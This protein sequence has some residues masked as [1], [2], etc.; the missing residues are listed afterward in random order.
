VY[1]YRT[2]LVEPLNHPQSI[3][4]AALVGMAQQRADSCDG[5]QCTLLRFTLPRSA[6]TLGAGP[7]TIELGVGRSTCDGRYAFYGDAA[8]PERVSRTVP[9]R[10]STPRVRS[11]FDP[12]AVAGGGHASQFG[13]ARSRAVRCMP[14][15][16]AG[17]LQFEVCTQGARLLEHATSSDGDCVG[18]W[19]GRWETGGRLETF[20]P[21]AEND[22]DLL[23]PL[24]Q[25]YCAL[26]AFG[27]GGSRSCLSAPRCLPGSDGCAW[28]KLPDSLCPVGASE[29]ELFGCHLGAEGNPNQE[30]D[31]PSALRCSQ[32]APLSA[33]DENAPDEGQCCDPL[34]AS[35]TLPACNA[36][37]TVYAY[38]AAAIEISDEPADS[39]ASCSASSPPPAMTPAPSP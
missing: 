10:W 31:Y 11:T 16:S 6:G 15:G 7:A 18:E 33:R 12:A 8:A 32:A 4:L 37:R 14:F 30:A 3:G 34:G 27:I 19:T 5:E 9:A 1:A 36:F 35:T 28:I 2:R 26:L 21:L 20:V 22:L 29:L 25:S 24:S 13:D 17:Q 23:P 39:Y 38:A